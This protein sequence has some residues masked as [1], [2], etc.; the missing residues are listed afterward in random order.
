MFS[1]PETSVH[2]L[3]NGAVSTVIAWQWN[4]LIIVFVLIGPDP[5]VTS[6]PK[7]PRLA[8]GEGWPSNT[9]TP[10]DTSVHRC[11]CQTEVSC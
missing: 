7:A 10:S 5:H 8:L 6:S 3:D 2:V 1:T 11:L 4:Y 9:H